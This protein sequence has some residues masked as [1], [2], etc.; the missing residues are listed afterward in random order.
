MN[1]R[2]TELQADLISLCT[3]YSAEKA[4]PPRIDETPERK[5]QW[6]GE[7]E[8]NVVSLATQLAL[9]TSGLASLVTDLN[10]LSE[11]VNQARKKIEAGLQK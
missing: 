8:E 4:R 5:A 2:A 9:A 3:H 1:E 6:M 10:R 7:M 11:S